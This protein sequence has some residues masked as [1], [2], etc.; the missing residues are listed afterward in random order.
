MLGAR[1]VRAFALSSRRQ[2]NVTDFTDLV[3][4]TRQIGLALSTNVGSFLS[5]RTIPLRALPPC[6]QNNERYDEHPDTNHQVDKQ[7]YLALAQR[8]GV[9]HSDVTAR[10]GKTETAGGKK[11]ASARVYLFTLCRGSEL[12]DVSPPAS[13]FARHPHFSR[14]LCVVLSL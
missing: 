2:R 9:F 7:C 10:G 12:A 4:L 3:H 14:H 8:S 1:S 13:D 6:T 5:P 11:K